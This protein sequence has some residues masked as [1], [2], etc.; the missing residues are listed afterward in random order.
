[1]KAQTFEFT[2]YHADWPER[3]ITFSYKVYIDNDTI[4]FFEEK[5][6]FPEAPL[7][8]DHIN[9]TILE[10]MLQSLHLITGISYFKLHC[11]KNITIKDYELT[12]EQA[13]FWN[14]VYTKGLG[15]FFYKN[16][17]D[18]RGL[19]NFPFSED[20][21]AK[22][23]ELPALSGVLIAIGGGKDSLFSGALLKKT[24]EKLSLLYG[25]D[26]QEESAKA[27]GISA[28]RV[29]RQLDDKLFDENAQKTFYQGHIPITLFWSFTT[30]LAAI[31]YGYNYVVF[32]NERSSNYGNVEYLGQEI[33]HQWSKS[34][35][36]EGLIRSY[37]STNISPS[38]EYFSLLRP[39]YE[40]EIV[41]RFSEYKEFLPIFSSCNRN[42]SIKNPLKNKR[43]CG[44]CPKCAFVF[45]LLSAFISKQEVLNI[46]GKNLYEDKNLEKTFRQLLG[47]EDIK[48]FECVG[49]PDE[50]KVAF[51]YAYK[52]GEFQ[53]DH[54][55]KMFEKDVLPLITDISSLEEEVF[56]YGDDSHIPEKFKKL[57]HI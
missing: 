19:I 48:P 10:A 43:W 2:S 7:E 28:M 17:I 35:E 8:I 1:M 30:I 39:W 41:R 14:E 37:I 47:I 56:S 34:M 13:L 23:M 24:D 3:T 50:V 21:M 42:F 18:F 26:I 53:D 5:L 51:H 6:T 16:S 45:S 55:M 52:K 44:E 29:K 31:I 11:A 36:A 4:L 25:H 15:E 12:K 49:T 32:S 9:N 33:N 57:L 54:S 46:F 38:I 27:L 20:T 40:I 22:P